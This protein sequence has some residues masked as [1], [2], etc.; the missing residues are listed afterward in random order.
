MGQAKR[1]RMNGVRNPKEQQLVMG[2]SKGMAEAFKTGKVPPQL[3]E[4]FGKSF[5]LNLEQNHL[6]ARCDGFEFA[7][8]RCQGKFGREVHVCTIDEARLLL[9]NFDELYG[10]SAYGDGSGKAAIAGCF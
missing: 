9:T 4:V 1:N 7:L 2:V 10:K 3:L 5:M 8:I 6:F